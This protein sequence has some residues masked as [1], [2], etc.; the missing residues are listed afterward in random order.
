MGKS[1]LNKFKHKTGKFLSNTA[2]VATTAFDPGEVAVEVSGSIIK[3]IPKSKKTGAIMRKVGGGINQAGFVIA[4]IPTPETKALGAALS[5]VG[6]TTEITGDIIERKDGAEATLRRIG[7]DL[8]SAAGGLLASEL[9]AGP[10]GQ[11]VAGQIGGAVGRKIGKEVGKEIDVHDADRK[12][13]KQIKDQ[14]DENK[15]ESDKHDHHNSVIV[16]DDLQGDT[17][18]NVG[19]T[20]TNDPKDS[21]KTADEFENDIDL[22][23]TGIKVIEFLVNNY[24]SF[25]HLSDEE[26]V[27]VL[28]EALDTQLLDDLLDKLIGVF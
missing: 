3:S 27:E 14:I 2:K 6:T 9:N 12:H 13:H 15:H 22:L 1:F 28:E 10:A 5:V 19:E 8:G 17:Q 23:D 25:E 7:S 24:D 16:P 4:Q 20:L 11:F 26:Q 18:T 21:A